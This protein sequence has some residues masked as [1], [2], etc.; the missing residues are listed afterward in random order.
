MQGNHETMKNGLGVTVDWLAYTLTGIDDIDDAISM[1]G[2]TRMDFDKMEHGAR[3]YKK[4]VKL[5]GY[6][7]Y[8]M[9]DGNADMGIHID[10]SGSA[11]G[12]II[13]SFSQTLRVSTPWGTGFEKDFDT[14]F[15]MELLKR[16]RRSGHITR[17]D[18]AIDDY[19]GRYFSTDDLVR[20]Y[21]DDEIICKF[22]N[23]QNVEQSEISGQKTGHTLYFGSRRS[24]IFLRVYDKQLEQNRKSD[25]KDST[26]W[27]RWE[28][29]LKG[30][31]ATAV[32]DNILS[33]TELG[34]ISMGVL[35][36]YFRIINHDNQ[37]RSRCSVNAVWKDFID[38]ISGLK[39]YL[40]R[41]EKDIEQ[42]KQWLKSQVMPTL[43]AV[44]MSDGGSLEFISDNMDSGVIRMKRPLREMVE[45]K[46][47]GG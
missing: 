27:V 41:E 35:G 37:N 47:A 28:L 46:L 38:G 8:I 45:K 32:A 33:G 26:P 19:G 42:K 7:V 24:D 1:L 40:A 11:V 9:Y 39:L 25:H 20:H 5:N 15:L 6:S 17:L 36:N 29:E 43:A 13:T 22:R 34:L 23:L 21:F 4:M 14:T 44:I 30:D 10:I 2:Y 16:I 3:G 31:R 12:E 18:L